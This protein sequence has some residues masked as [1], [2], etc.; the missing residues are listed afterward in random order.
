[1]YVENTD[2]SRNAGLSVWSE[3]PRVTELSNKLGD[4]NVYGEGSWGAGLVTTESTRCSYRELG[5]ASQYPH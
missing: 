1:M 2:V 3:A 4:K 5:I